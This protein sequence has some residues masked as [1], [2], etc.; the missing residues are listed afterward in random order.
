MGAQLAD[1][2][3]PR[4]QSAARRAGTCCANCQT[5]TTTLWR[6]NANGDPVCNA[7]GLY[8]KLHNVSR[9]PRPGDPGDPP[10][11]PSPARLGLGS[12]RQ[13]GFPRG[14]RAGWRTAPWSGISAQK[15]SLQWVGFCRVGRGAAPYRRFS[16]QGGQEGPGGQ[17]AFGRGPPGQ[18][19]SVVWPGGE[20]QPLKALRGPPG[21]QAAD[22]E[23]GRH[24]DPEPEDVQ[25]VQEEQEGVRVLRGAVQVCAGQGLPIQRRRPGGAHGACGPPAAL[26][27]LRSHPAHPDAHPPPLQPLLR[28]PP[29]IQHGD[30]HGLG[31]APRTDRRTPGTALQGCGGPSAQLAGPPRD[32]GPCPPSWTRAASPVGAL[33]TTVKP[34][35]GKPGCTHTGFP[36]RTVSVKDNSEETRVGEGHSGAAEKAGEQAEEFIW[37]RFLTRM[38][39]LGSW[40]Q[41]PRGQPAC[42][43]LGAG[44][45]GDLGPL[46]K[47]RTQLG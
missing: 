13:K 29:P 39:R 24:P 20:L 44:L 26:Q 46:C 47:R 17:W 16:W 15:Q 42:P 28:P 19:G 31:T 33:A 4:P 7:C 9:P 12:E 14:G 22:H 34:L 43:A 11:P 10:G 40:G 25:Q 38:G 5:T 1:P 35:P 6:R 8:Y 18:A 3:P 37:L 2:A 27:P 36:P 41:V 23:E 30:R 32:R 45:W 21:E